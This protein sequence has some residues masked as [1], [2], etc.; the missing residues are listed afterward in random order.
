MSQNFLNQI[1]KAII[2]K[3]FRPELR[4]YYSKAGIHEIPYKSYAILLHIALVIIGII[5]IASN[6]FGEIAH[7]HPLL[8]GLVVFLFWMIAGGLIVLITIG[9]IYFYLNLKIFNRVKEMDANLADYLT[10]VSTN[11]KGGLSFEKALWT[12]IKPE[13]GVLAEEMSLVSKKVMTGSELKEALQE[14]SEKYDSPS[15]KRTIDLLLGQLESGGEIAAVLDETIETLR[16][17]KIL[18]EEMSANT[19]MFT[20]FIGVIVTVISPLLFALALN[21]LH[22]LIN[23]SATVAPALAA[24]SSSMPFTMKEIEIDSEDFKTFSVLALAII[25]IFASLILSIIQKG[26]IKS[27]VK[28]V[29]LFLFAAIIIYFIFLS[30]FGGM[31]SFI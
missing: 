28:Y 17:T 21:L 11:L 23:V 30:V 16:K 22:I 1:G 7:L 26:D 12:A 9:A 27:G 4:L 14:Y 3:T 18:K 6:F 10:L 19:L 8:V 5:Y 25:S 2:P 29:P 13:F 15:I 20:I 31:F 24:S